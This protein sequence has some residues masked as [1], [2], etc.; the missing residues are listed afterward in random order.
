MEMH[1]GMFEQSLGGIRFSQTP[2]WGENS[3]VVPNF[4]S[5]TTSAYFK[6]EQ[7]VMFIAKNI[8]ILIYL[9]I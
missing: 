9:C 6:M 2:V 5:H 1:E 3:T 7:E 4:Y 8:Y